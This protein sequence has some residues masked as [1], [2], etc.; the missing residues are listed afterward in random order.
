VRSTLPEWLEQG[1]DYSFWFSNA[2]TGEF[3][4]FI[5]GQP[6]KPWKKKFAPVP[7]E[8]HDW[9]GPFYPSLRSIKAYLVHV[10]FSWKGGRHRMGAKIGALRAPS[11]H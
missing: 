7:G 3:G 8:S 10:A 4:G 9:R 2:E 1:I 11:I 5:Y 6:R